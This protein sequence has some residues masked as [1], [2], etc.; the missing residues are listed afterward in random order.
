MTLLSV[1][2]TT[3]C[4][5]STQRMSFG[6]NGGQVATPWAWFMR[7]GV[8]SCGT[9]PR[10]GSVSTTLYQAAPT[11]SLPK[12][13]RTVHSRQQ[14]PQSA[15]LLASHTPP[16]TTP[17]T[18]TSHRQITDSPASTTSSKTFT[19][20]APSPRLSP[21]TWTSTLTSQVFTNTLLVTLKM[22]T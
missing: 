16:S 17:T 4:C 20:T 18:T 5:N 10:M 7:K 11:T 8:V 1:T 6:C 13:S 15:S 14:L 21:F 9:L 12:V 22:V 3:T 19:T 2:N